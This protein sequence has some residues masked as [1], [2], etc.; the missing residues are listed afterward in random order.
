ML[1]D[2]S[3]PIVGCNDLRFV[4]R[5]LARGFPLSIS[6]RTQ[7]IAES[8]FVLVQLLGI[9]YFGRTDLHP[10]LD[11]IDGHLMGLGVRFVVTFFRGHESCWRIQSLSVE[12]PPYC[13][14]R[15]TVNSYNYKYYYA[16]AS[17]LRPAI[18]ISP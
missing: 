5:L 9:S 2:A 1:N 14:I 11:A 10:A 15:I 13:L 18:R 8:T 16:I 4:F 12:A 7:L 17:A 3:S 6:V